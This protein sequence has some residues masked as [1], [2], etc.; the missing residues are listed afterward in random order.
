MRMHSTK[1]TTR[2]SG[3]P[4]VSSHVPVSSS[5]LVPSMHPMPMATSP[6]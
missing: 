4:A 6:K 5:Q 2:F 1:A 3:P